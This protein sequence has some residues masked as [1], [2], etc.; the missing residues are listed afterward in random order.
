MNWLYI[1]E[2][3]VLVLG[4]FIFNYIYYYDIYYLGFG[5][6]NIYIVLV[7]FYKRKY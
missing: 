2:Y 4:K 3:Y 5:I 7:I 1:I 6:F